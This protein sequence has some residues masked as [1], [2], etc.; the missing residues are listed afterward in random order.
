ME[1]QKQINWTNTIFLAGSPVAA[2]FCTY[3]WLNTSFNLNTAIFAF[4]MFCACGISITAGYHRLFA[5]RSYDAHPLVRFIFLFFG[6]AAL[7]G[8]ALTWSLDHRNHH[9]YVDDNEKDPYS[10][11]K[12]FLFAH[13]I[14]LFYKGNDQLRNRDK[15]VDLT[16]DKM[17][18]FQHD[19][20]HLLG[21]AVCF[22][23]PT[24][25]GA[26]W[27]DAWGGFLIA[28]LLRVV[29]NH[30]FTFL[31]NSACHMFGKQT[32]SDSHSAKDSWINAL[33]TFGEGYHNYHHEFPSDYR[34]GIRAYDFD[35]TKWLIYA[36]YK[37]GLAANL[38]R[39]SPERI[40]LRRLQMRE[41][42]LM[43]KLSDQ[44]SSIVD[45]ANRFMKRF[46]SRMQPAIEKLTK[47]SKE[48][49][50]MIKD[51]NSDKRSQKA[52]KLELK[53]AEKECKKLLELWEAMVE[54]IT[55]KLV[56]VPA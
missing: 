41:K 46:D 18:M 19:Y 20:Y 17:L 22:V 47:L 52:L 13:I 35:P 48:Y 40:V 26:L 11:N 43:S 25:L 4:F 39:I 33:V 23:L 12:G 9:R 37:L 27:G 30:Q 50:A 16:N 1:H 2:I 34:N 14:W 8:S 15:A 55:T 42:E 24:M 44:P 32:Y 10:I 36:F 7:Q 45:F 21:I 3:H 54:S 5:H 29:L 6:V 38:K 56:P 28:G 51:V 31:I 53:V 49:Q